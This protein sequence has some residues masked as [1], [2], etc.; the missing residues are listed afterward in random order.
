MMRSSVAVLRFLL[1]ALTGSCGGVHAN[2]PHAVYRG[3]CQVFAAAAATRLRCP[4]ASVRISGPGTVE[5]SN[6]GGGEVCLAQGCGLA[7]EYSC[8]QGQP[9]TEGDPVAVGP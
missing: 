4:R 5:F 9:C 2:G 8:D 1:L 7:V 3:D 6:G